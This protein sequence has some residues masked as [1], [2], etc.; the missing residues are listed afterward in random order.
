MSRYERKEKTGIVLPFDAL[1]ALLLLPAEEAKELVIA[2][3]QY[4]QGEPPQITSPTVASIWPTYQ[5][6]IAADDFQYWKTS[7]TNAFNR[8]SKDEKAGLTREQWERLH[9][10]EYV[11]LDERI[12]GEPPEPP[13]AAPEPEEDQETA[14]T[15]SAALARWM[16][17]KGYEPEQAALILPRMQ[18]QGREYGAAAVAAAVDRAIAARA[19]TYQPEATP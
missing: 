4:G 2:M 18:A 3:L 14:D 15:L 9:P 7:R 10:E 12:A 11:S 16:D 13:Q 8:L 17:Y 19:D 6:R 1:P 5:R